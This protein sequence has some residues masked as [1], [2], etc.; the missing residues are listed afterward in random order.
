MGGFSFMRDARLRAAQAAVLWL[1]G[2]PVQAL[3]WR[4]AL[5]RINFHGFVSQGYTWT[6]AN[7]L[8]GHSE[9]GSPNFTEAGLNVRL[10]LLPPVSIAAQGIYRHAGKVENQVQLDY[11]FLE[12]RPYTGPHLRLTLRGGRIKNPFGLYNETRDVAFTRPSIL[13]PQSI[14]FDRSRSLYLSSDGGQLAFDYTQGKH[15]ISFRFN[16]GLYRDEFDEV[17]ASIFGFEAPGRISANR[18]LLLGQLRYEYDAGQLIL[19][20]SLADVDLEYRSASSGNDPIQTLAAQPFHTG[21]IHSRPLLL[22][23]QVNGERWSL[24]GEYSLQFQK[25]SHFGP[26]FDRD[27]TSQG[28]YVQGHY[29]I[30]PNLQLLGRYDVYYLDR[31][32]TN[33][34]GLG[35]EPLRPR[36]AAWAKDWT[37]GLRWDITPHWMVA[38]EY[39]YVD[40][41]AWLPFQDNPH[42]LDTQRRWH[43]VLGLIS[44]RF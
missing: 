23:L 25:V 21:R 8:F 4:E 32:D 43:L 24:T 35:L 2:L 7:N 18:P 14:Y 26:G 1:L 3:E 22:S 31:S 13:L 20:A 11:G 37:G 33:G 5:E 29:R 41:T 16:T 28:W 15:E 6:S 44:L 27:F 10:D 12:W 38:A 19:A 39:H 42:P 36:H 30:L 40:G 34:S 17:K 9:N